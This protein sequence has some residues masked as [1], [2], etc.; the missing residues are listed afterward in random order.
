MP[1]TN[2]GTTGVEGLID[3][4]GNWLV[5]GASSLWEWFT[6]D[7]NAAGLSALIGAG[8]GYFEDTA[9]PKVGW[10]GE[11]PKYTAHREQLNYDKGPDYDPL[12]GAQGRRYFTDTFHGVTPENQQPMS[13]ADAQAAM[14]LQKGV[15]NNQ[16]ARGGIVSALNNPYK[17]GHTDGMSDEL[18]A[19]IDNQ[20]PAALSHGEMVIPADVVSHMGNGN[21]DA[22]AE[23]FYAMMDRVR[24]ART[25][26]KKQGK[27]IDPNS[28]IPA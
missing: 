22:G 15:L 8:V 9:Q 14:E 18:S 7:N 6:K 11:V 24:Q 19:V 2:E 1:E 23:Q 21:S 25:G 20:Q 27:Q 3:P 4:D 13:S 26:S 17:R 10:Q 16:Y 28:F 5:D 12:A